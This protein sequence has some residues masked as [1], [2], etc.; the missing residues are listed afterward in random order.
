VVYEK[1]IPAA[2]YISIRSNICPPNNS[3]SNQWC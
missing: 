2:Q 1:V 3:A